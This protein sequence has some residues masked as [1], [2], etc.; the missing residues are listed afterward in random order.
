[1]FQNLAR[2]RTVLE[3]CPTVFLRC[4]RDVDGDLCP[5]DGRVA[6]KTVEAETGDVEDIFTPQTNL[7]LILEVWILLRTSR[8]CVVEF[9][10]RLS[11]LTS[12]LSRS[13][14]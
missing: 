7:S 12:I 1:M 14:G 3:E 13:S 5:S 11:R 6:D 9:A 4:K 8:V 10:L 2:T